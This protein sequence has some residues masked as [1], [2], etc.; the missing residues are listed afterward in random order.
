[1]Y[2]GNIYQVDEMS[3]DCPYQP[4]HNG[5]GCGERYF[6]ALNRSAPNNLLE[7]YYK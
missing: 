3:R 6:I 1:M 4:T 2:P 5:K 7:K